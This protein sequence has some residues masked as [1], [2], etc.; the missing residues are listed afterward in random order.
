MK[1]RKNKKDKDKKGKT[2]NGP[3]RS[4]DEYYDSG[5][6]TPQQEAAIHKEE[7]KKLKNL[8]EEEFNVKF[9]KMLVREGKFC[10]ALPGRY[11]MEHAQ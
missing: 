5:G 10:S 7:L 4:K 9:E 3:Q 1:S 8:P 11:I 2:L 6:P